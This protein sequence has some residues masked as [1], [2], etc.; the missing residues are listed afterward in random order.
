MYYLKNEEK[1]KK[2]TKEII[3]ILK[4]SGEEIAGTLL[5]IEKHQVFIATDKFAMVHH[6][7]AD[8]LNGVDSELSERMRAF[9][10]EILE[11]RQ[12][13]GQGAN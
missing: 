2:N 8:V 12:Q 4:E 7:I 11:Q 1:I 13:S 3:E 10:L 5:R 6:V 9:T